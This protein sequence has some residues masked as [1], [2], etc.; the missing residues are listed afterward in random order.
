MHSYYRSVLFIH[1]NV[2]QKCHDHITAVKSGVNGNLYCLVVASCDKLSE[3]E[4]RARVWRGRRGAPAPMPR[5]IRHRPSVAPKSQV[6]AQHP[7][8]LSVRILC[9]I[10]LIFLY[11]M[12]LAWYLACWADL[13]EIGLRRFENG[14]WGTA[15]VDRCRL[16]VTR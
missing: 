15:R 3:S 16:V 7:Y 8:T 4:V 14:A 9:K 6:C 1:F 2:T 13:F 5:S 10:L 12:L 11:S